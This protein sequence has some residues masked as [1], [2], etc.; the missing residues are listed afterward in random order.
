MSRIGKKPVSI[1]DKVE[2]KIDGNTLH[3]KGPLGEQSITISSNIDL[4]LEDKKL[5]FTRKNDHKQAKSDQGLLNRLTNNAIIGVT[6]GYTKQLEVN[7]VGYK[8]NLKGKNLELN[9]GL[10]HPVVYSPHEGIQL[11]VEKNI[12]IVSGIDK[13]LVGQTAAEIRSF[14]KPE[15]YK[16]KGI[17]YVEE[18]IRRKAGKMAA[19]TSS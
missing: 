19:A 15:P 16:G 4:K 11:K 13:Q 9:I 10:S 14:K 17:K 1:P 7:G 8:I 6:S 5:V 12:I 3:I 2:T 18:H